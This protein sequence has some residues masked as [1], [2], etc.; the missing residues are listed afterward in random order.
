ML[1]KTIFFIALLTVIAIF[2]AI[3]ISFKIRFLEINIVKTQA[4]NVEKKEVL[5]KYKAEWNYLNN[6][7]YLNELKV[8][9][10]PSFTTEKGSRLKIESIEKLTTEK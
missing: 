5:Q 2:L 1:R 4:S 7:N 3:Y 10:L 6:E 8:K 9:N